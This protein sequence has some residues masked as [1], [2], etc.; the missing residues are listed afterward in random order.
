MNEAPRNNKATDTQNSTEN[1]MDDATLLKRAEEFYSAERLLK[2][3]ELLKQVKD[4]ENL[5]TER[6]KMILFWAEMVESGI[7]KLTQDPEKDGSPWIKQKEKHGYRDFLIYYQVTKENKLIARIDSSFESSLLVPLISVFSESDLYASWMPS[8]ERPIK[9][10]VTL[11]EKL[12]E[13]GRGNQII[14]VR[15]ALTWPFSDRDLITRVVAV[16]AIEDDHGCIAIQA[17]NQTSEDDPVIPKATKETVQLDFS[18]FIMIRACPP[19]HPCV[20][21]STNHNKDEEP[22]VLL[23]LSFEADP[24]ISALPQSVQ[25]FFTRTVL[26]RMWMSLLQVAEEV[27]DGK[28][29]VHKEAIDAKR[30]LYDWIEERTGVMIKNLKEQQITPVQAS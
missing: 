6:H 11:S 24:H 17:L 19:D 23:S 4:Q 21:R 16:D 28:R 2:A 30:D 10:G 5:F 26:G 25:N 22:L 7:E 15:T 27:R 8:W 12:K 14:H 18:N 13:E 1:I 29:P 20:T 3:A 9:L